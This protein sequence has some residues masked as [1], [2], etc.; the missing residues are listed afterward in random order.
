M[1]PAQIELDAL[2]RAALSAVFGEDFQNSKSFRLV[3]SFFPGRIQ[4]YINKFEAFLK[5]FLDEEGLVDGAG[6]KEAVSIYYPEISEVIPGRKFRL[7][8][9]SDKAIDLY[10]RLR[11]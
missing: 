5:P 1:T 3:E 6:L 11:Q 8:E 7:S 4:T 2:E 10:R 9:I